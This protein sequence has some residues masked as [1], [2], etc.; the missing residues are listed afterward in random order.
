M[1]SRSVGVQLIQPDDKTTA[2]PDLNVVVIHKLFR[3]SDGL[4][5]VTTNQRLVRDKISAASN[6]VGPV[7]CQMPPKK[8]PEIIY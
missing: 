3:H 5:I 7:M 4:T 2:A 6:E 1:E 8:I